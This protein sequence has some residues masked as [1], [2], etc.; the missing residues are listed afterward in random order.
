[1]NSDLEK[2]NGAADKKINQRLFKRLILYYNV[3]CGPWGH[4][5]TYSKSRQ[6]STRPPGDSRR[7]VRPAARTRSSGGENPSAAFPLGVAHAGPGPLTTLT[8]VSRDLYP[9]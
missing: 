4:A 6:R 3:V 1:M 7:A 2:L 5:G 9:A 8:D